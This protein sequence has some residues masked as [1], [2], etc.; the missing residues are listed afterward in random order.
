MYARTSYFDGDDRVQSAN[1]RFERFEV[2]ILVRKDTKVAIV[3]SKT[4]AGVDVFLRR[5][6]P[7]VTLSLFDREGMLVC[8]VT[9]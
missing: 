9:L 6:E 4:N 8:F 5:L 2:A 7:R 1:G 3:D